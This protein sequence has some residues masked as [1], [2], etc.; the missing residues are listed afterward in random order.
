[1]RYIIPRNPLI[2]EIKEI[3]TPTEESRL[4]PLIVGEHGTGKTSLIRLAVNSMNEN[5][6]KGVVYVDI[7]I[8]CDLEVNVTKAV[9]EALGWSPDPLINPSK[10]NYNSS[11]LVLFEANRFAVVSLGG[12]L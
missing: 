12:I 10:R 7:P 6:P 8:G 2:E 3:I 9:Q 11:L 5:K 4:Y 1:M